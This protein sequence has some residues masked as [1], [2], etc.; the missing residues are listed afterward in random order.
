MEINK[1]CKL[2]LRDIYLYDIKS[3]HY[4]ILEKYGFDL[5]GIEKDNKLKRNTQIGKMMQTNLRLTSFLRNITKNIVDEFIIENKILEDE[6]IL[7]QYDG[8]IISRPLRTMTQNNITLDFRSHFQTLIISIDRKSYI[9]FDTTNNKVIIKGVSYKYETIEKVYTKLVKINYVYRSS[10]F[11]S[12]QKIKDEFMNF[13][14]SLYFC[15]PIDKDKYTIFLK[16]YGEVEIS[17]HVAKIMDSND[18]DKERYFDFYISPFTKSIVNE[19]VR[20]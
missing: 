7:R 4:R 1:N 20:I 11:K 5:T 15:I 2:F 13:S 16:K 14:N 12:L 17:K 10:I 18:I 6:I 8:L 19:F 9:A 3:C